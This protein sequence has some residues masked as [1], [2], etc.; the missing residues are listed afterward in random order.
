MRNPP[1][2]VAGLCYASQEIRIWPLEASILKPYPKAFFVRLPPLRCRG[3]LVGVDFCL[4]EP[5]KK[6]VNA[7]KAIAEK[8]LTPESFSST[9]ALVK[10]A[11]PLIEEYF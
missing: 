9:A 11:A 8:G 1:A 3:F 10:Q 6:W 5:T 2:V 4:T 7:A